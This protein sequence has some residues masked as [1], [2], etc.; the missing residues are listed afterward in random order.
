MSRRTAISESWP[1]STA[2]ATGDTRAAFAIA[3]LE[4]QVIEFWRV[5]YDISM[6]QQ[7]MR[8]ARLPSHWFNGSRVGR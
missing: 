3:D 7:R 1:R 2:L 8:A 4:H 5:P 6:V